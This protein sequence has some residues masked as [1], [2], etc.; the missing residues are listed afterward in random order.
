MR[1]RNTF[2]PKRNF[3]WRSR[4]RSATSNRRELASGRGT[5]SRRGHGNRNYT[6]AGV[7]ELIAHAVSN[8]TNERNRPNA[9]RRMNL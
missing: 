8:S 9:S 4:A 2:T 1:D 3:V 6:T 5:L 7:A